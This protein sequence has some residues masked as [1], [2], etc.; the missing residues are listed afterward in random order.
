MYKLSN[1]GRFFSIFNFKLEDCIKRRDKKELIK[2]LKKPDFPELYDN[3]LLSGEE[4]ERVEAMK[5]K[6]YFSILNTIEQLKFDKSDTTILPHIEG[7][8]TSNIYSKCYKNIC[9]YEVLELENFPGN[10]IIPNKIYVADSSSGENKSYHFN[11]MKIIT[12][13][14]SGDFN[15][16]K[17]GKPFSNK[18]K[19]NIASKYG[20]EIKMYRRYLKS[21]K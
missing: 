16:P 9:I 17:T 15:N 7:D 14:A 8:T 18:A 11:I 21:V 3:M 12:R 6:E 1:T 13:F 20:K 5:R 10:H 4:I 19:N 2:L